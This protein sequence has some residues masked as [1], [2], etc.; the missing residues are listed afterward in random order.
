MDILGSAKSI[1]ALSMAYL[2]LKIN[3]GTLQEAVDGN[4]IDFSENQNE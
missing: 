3:V 1:N 2:A 4:A